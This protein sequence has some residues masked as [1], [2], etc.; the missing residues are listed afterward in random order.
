M[1]NSKRDHAPKAKVLNNFERNLAEEPGDAESIAWLPWGKLYSE[2]DIDNTAADKDISAFTGNLI[3]MLRSQHFQL[4][5]V[6][7]LT[8]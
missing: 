4:P 3:T 7:L 2:F 1:P 8:S 6:A 5:S